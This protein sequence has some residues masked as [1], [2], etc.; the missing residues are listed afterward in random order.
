M[1]EFDYEEKKRIAVVKWDTQ[2]EDQDWFHP[3]KEALKSSQK[4]VDVQVGSNSL[5]MPWWAFLST[6]SEVEVF[7]RAYGLRYGAHYLISPVAKELLL[8]ASRNRNSYSALKNA[9]LVS[10]KNLYAKLSKSG[11][12]RNLTPEQ[13]RNVRFLSSLPA[14]ATFSVP[15][16]GKTTEALATFAYRYETDDKL[17]VVAPKNAFSAWEEQ[18]ELCFCDQG[19][20]F[21]RLRG[22]SS[23]PVELQKDRY[24][25]LIG[26]QQLVQVKEYIY[27]FVSRDNV[28]IFLDESHRIKGANNIT[29]NAVLGLSFLAK[30]K[31]IM[32]GTPMPQSTADLVPQLRF[33]FPELSSSAENVVETVKSIYVRTTKEE[34]GLPKV[35][36]ITIPIDM[37]PVQ[38]RVYDLIRSEI[39]R[40]AASTLSK[41]DRQAFRRL[42]K[43]IVH[44]LQITSNPAL[45][46]EEISF[47]HSQELAN[48]L[49]EGTGPKIQYLLRRVRKLAS[50]NRKVLVW[51]NFVHNVEFL[52]Y[53]LQDIGSVFIHGGVDAG[54]DN[55]EDTREGKI[56]SFHEDE[57]IKVL[58][59]NPAAASEGISLHSVCNYAIYLDRNFNAAQY[60]QSIDRI[61]RLGLGMEVDTTVEVLECKKS[62][63]EVVQD[64][65]GYK[66]G[67][68]AEVLND[69]SLSVSSAHIEADED[70][71]NFGAG[72]IDEH[73][74]EEV[75]RSLNIE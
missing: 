70:D 9:K 57:S 65:L 46:A 2:D 74:I 40:E 43:S 60:L 67:K 24:L 53:A 12:C 5:T 26:Y 23:I 72:G 1:I 4:G 49:K 7:I 69:P 22:T 56:R 52:A 61:H 51:T 68:M 58:V 64:R 42:G 19:K 17:L 14:G 35:N 66:V 16:A 8:L 75:L 44:A 73:D 3:L 62:I 29:T 6:G 32:S 47:A 10:K 45:L 71:L 34:L 55:D 13:L 27:D 37:D 59:A 28:H 50:E 25:F 38:R 54:D 39:V 21:T 31:L 15:G 30:S 63:D 18:L 20:Q 33:L 11:F 36:H 41:K 48:A